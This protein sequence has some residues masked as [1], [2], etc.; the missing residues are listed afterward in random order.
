M[1]EY[2]KYAID[3]SNYTDAQ[4]ETDRDLS[5][6]D[7]GGRTAPDGA[8]RGEASGQRGLQ[9]PDTIDRS[10]RTSVRPMYETDSD[11]SSRDNGG[12]A[13]PDDAE[14]GEASGRAAPQPLHRVPHPGTPGPGLK[15][16]AS[17]DAWQQRARAYAQYAINHAT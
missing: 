6:R 2:G 17:V 10:D 15:T 13:A 9:Q 3:R 5:A 16:K 12:R 4:Y 11:S 7:N 1:R 8:A 14:R